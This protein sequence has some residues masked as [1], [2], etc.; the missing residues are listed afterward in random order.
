MPKKSFIKILLERRIPHIMASYLVAGTSL[1]LFVEYL[2]DKYQFPS[3]YP[4]LALFALIGILP[5]VII[6]SYFHGA[7]GKD[8]WTNVE[9]V[10]IPI[11]VLFI[12]G[13][14]FF[15]DS[16]NIW[17]MD[18]NISDNDIPNVHLIY[19][20]SPEENNNFAYRSAEKY[21]S[22]AENEGSE[23]FSFDE[24][25]LKNLRS[26]IEAGLYSE[27]YNQNLTIKVLKNDEEIRFVDNSVKKYIDIDMQSLAGGIYKFFDEPTHIIFVRVYAMKSIKGEILEYVYD[28]AERNNMIISYGTPKCDK[29]K[30]SV[31]ITNSVGDSG[32]LCFV[33]ED[34]L[35]P[36]HCYLLDVAQYSWAILE[37]FEDEDVLDGSDFNVLEEVDII[38]FCNSICK[39]KK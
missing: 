27:F 34:S 36:V 21:L 32:L 7:P 26:N 33:K 10:G 39:K 24:L 30:N 29:S 3:Y 20:G 28:V 5:S 37:G 35:T 12:A 2:V 19:I 17:E 18:Q 11:N 15:G 38:E 14:L 6:L 4:T 23:I 1:I 8:E 22:A 13:A 16:L 31:V 25:E 9:K